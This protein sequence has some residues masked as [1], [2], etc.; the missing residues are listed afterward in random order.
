MAKLP[1]QIKE[2]QE[3]PSK[4]IQQV[5][6]YELCQGDHQTG[7]Y[8]P[9]GKEVNNMGNQNQNQA[10]QPRQQN[11]QNNQGYQGYKQGWRKDGGNSNR[12]NLYQNTTQTSQPQSGS[13]KMEETLTQFMKILMANQKR[14]EAKIKNIENQVGQLAKKLSEQQTRSSFFINTQTNLKEH[15]KAIVTRMEE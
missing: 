11:Y 12:Q 13:S 14:N 5:A 8:P 6:S 1:K 2:M 10:Y 9:V 4:Q 7:F 15:Y 3:I